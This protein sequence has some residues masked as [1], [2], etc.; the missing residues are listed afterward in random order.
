MV[1][2][3]QEENHGDFRLAP[4]PFAGGKIHDHQEIDVPCLVL[5]SVGFSDVVLIVIG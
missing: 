5:L 4:T 3:K 2:G 1:T